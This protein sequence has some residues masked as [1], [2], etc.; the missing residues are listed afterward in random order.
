MCSWALKTT[1]SQRA[2][3]AQLIINERA[4]NFSSIRFAFV[5]EGA[6]ARQSIIVQRHQALKEETNS[7]PHGFDKD[8]SAGKPD[9]IEAQHFIVLQPACQ[10]HF[11]LTS[12][13]DLIR[14]S[15]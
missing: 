12:N 11:L 9:L 7:Q 4:V 5:N 6:T 15:I 2:C 10:N 8:A 14:T 1:G 3:K 13:I